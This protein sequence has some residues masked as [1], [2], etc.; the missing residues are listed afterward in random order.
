ME[1]NIVI[2]FLSVFNNNAKNEKYN[3]ETGLF[4]AMCSHTNETGLKYFE[5]KLAQEGKKID[6]VYTIVTQKAKEI[7]LAPFKDLF[8]G[9]DYPIN[10]VPMIAEDNLSGSFKTISNLFDALQKE[11]ADDGELVIHADMTGGFRHANMLMIAL[12][13]MLKYSGTQTGSVIYT[14]YTNHKVE[15]ANDLVDMFTM[16]G[17]AE[18]FAALGNVMQIQK[19]FASVPNKSVY[20]ENLL[21]KMENFTEILKICSHRR[22]FLKSIQLLAQSLNAYRKFLDKPENKKNLSEQEEFFSKLLPTIEKEYAGILQYA[23]TNTLNNIPQIIKWCVK[24]G[25]LQQAVT[26]YTEWV[27]VFVIDKG[28]IVIKTDEIKTKC[29]DNALSW[30]DWRIYFFKEF[31][32]KHNNRPVFL[33]DTGNEFDY[34]RLRELVEAEMSADEI[35][36]AVEKYKNQ[37][38]TKTLA[39]LNEIKNFSIKNKDKDYYNLFLAYQALPFGSDVKN[40]LQKACPTNTSMLNFIKKRYNTVNDVEGILLTCIPQISKKDIN[41][42][43]EFNVAD[44]ANNTNANNSKRSNVLGYLLKTGE[45]STEMTKADFIECI[46]GYMECVD[47]WRNTFNHAAG[48]VAGKEDNAAISASIIKRM[49]TLEKYIK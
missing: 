10:D 5:W 14:N 32:P 38:L 27:P 46:D 33:A 8:T 28:L 37:N 23:N 36:N 35:I 31:K 41:T 21:D 25:F 4:E 1:K 45:L 3:D 29:H 16:L 48:I 42:I 24:K 40:I 26:L 49:E 6:A 39:I 19:Y 13:Q 7:A 44:A 43:F 34:G 11:K 17:G 47:N 2:F 9:R 22:N 30:S 18:E 12:L 15:N 20:L